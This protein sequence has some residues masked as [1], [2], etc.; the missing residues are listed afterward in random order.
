MNNKALF[1][2]RDGVIN[3]DTGHP[4]NINEIQFVEGIFELCAMACDLGYRIIIVTNQAGIAKGYYDEAQFLCV[5]DWMI[6]VFK[7]RNIEILDFYF[8]PH[9]ID[10]LGQYKKNCM[11]R[12]PE[13]GMI[14]DASVDHNINLRNSVIVGDKISDM[15]AGKSAGVGE[16]LLFKSA[17][18]EIGGL[19]ED[20]HVFTKMSDIAEYLKKVEDK[21]RNS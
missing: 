9:H 8:C 16:K 3:V 11:R 7:K 12:K 19:M 2:D 21:Y 20:I 5:M 6:E 1:L 17:N 13:P 15:E 14:L 10:G 4:H 18:D